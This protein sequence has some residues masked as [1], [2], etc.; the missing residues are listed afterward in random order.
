M[1]YDDK[2]EEWPEPER[3]P[4]KLEHAREVFAATAGTRQRMIRYAYMIV[5]VLALAVVILALTR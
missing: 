1:S 3:D 4:K 2:D 5:G